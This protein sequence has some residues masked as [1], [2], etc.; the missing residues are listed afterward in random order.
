MWAIEA[1]ELRKR[2]GTREV[3]K[4]VSLQVAQGELYGF[5]GR[6]GAGKSTLINMLTGIDYPTSGSCLLLGAPLPNDAVKR[7][8]GV[9][10]DY[11]SMYAGMTPVTLLKFLA[12]VSGHKLDSAAAK[13]LLEQVG[14]SAHTNVKVGKLSFGS[15]KKL[16]LAQAIAHNPSLI[17]LDE[18][19]SGLDA[20]SAIQVQGVIRNLKKQGKTVFLTSHNLFEVEKLCDR[21][22]IMKEGQIAVSGTM[23]EL[24]AY[25]RSTLTV[26]IKHKAIQPGQQ[27]VLEDY[28]NEIGHDVDLT[29]TRTVLVLDAEDKISQI[30]RAFH[31]CRVDVLRV[32]VDEPSLEDIFL[33]T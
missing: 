11:S 17:F 9:L 30:V 13:Q 31:E 24:R 2:Y 28:L 16:G 27:S 32:E 26:T 22:S 3:V 7:Q 25:Y 14:L 21:V 18:P 29:D 33:Q 23:D 19:T 20:E 1:K 12:G 8:I 5:L 6:N 4:G 10:P 15:K